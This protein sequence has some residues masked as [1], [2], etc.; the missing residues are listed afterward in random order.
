MGN[1]LFPDENRSREAN[2]PTPRKRLQTISF[3]GKIAHYGASINKRSHQLK[4]SEEA[5]WVA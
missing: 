2:N 3:R 1:D 4:Y 5:N